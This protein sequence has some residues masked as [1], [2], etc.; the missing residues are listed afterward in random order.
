MEKGESAS[1]LDNNASGLFGI[2]GFIA[3]IERQLLRLVSL[4]FGLSVIVITRK[5]P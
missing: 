1:D 2:L 4:P 3:Q 5:K